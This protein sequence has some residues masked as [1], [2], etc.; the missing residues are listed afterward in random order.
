MALILGCIADDL[1]GATDLANTLVKQGMKTVQTIGLP[2]GGLTDLGDVSAVV[3]ALKSR[4]IAVEEAVR[5]SLDALELLR[6]GGARQFLFKY[7]STFDSTDQGN[8]GPVTEALLNALE[9]DI[10]IACPAFPTAG[11]TIYNGHLFVGDTPLAESPMR[12]HPLTPMTDS[13]LVSVLSR[14]SVGKVGLV[15]F[16]AVD[17]GANAIRAALAEL[18]SNGVR[19]AIVDAISDR[20][21]MVIG[22]AIGDLP[23][24]TGGSGIALGLP[25]N[26]RRAGALPVEPPDTTLPPGSG[27]AAVLAGSCSQATRA[28]VAHMSEHRPTLQVNPIEA[29]ADGK[30][31]A[32]R[33]L[34][35]ALPKLADGPVLVYATADPEDVRTAQQQLGVAAAGEAVEQVMADVAQG[36]VAAGVGRLVVAGGETSGAVVQALGVKRLRIGAEIDPG[37]PWTMSIDAPRL[38]LALKSGNFGTPDFFLK[39][40]DRLT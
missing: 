4:T 23:L 27:L 40:F 14:Q 26:F 32:A 30:G 12:D 24:V 33:A 25:E 16:S 13:N 19:Q 34:E 20:H 9:S 28:Q 2:S 6:D 29:A 21:L 1:T 39:A 7:C 36:L 22:E 10:S 38:H 5:Q 18:K 17:A 31:V 11:R 8:I 35:W 15:P 37:V 3:I